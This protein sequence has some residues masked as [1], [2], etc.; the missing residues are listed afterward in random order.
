MNTNTQKTLGFFLITGLMAMLPGATQAQCGSIYTTNT[1]LTASVVCSGNGPVLAASNITLD[2][3]GHTI[4][5]IGSGIGI[6][7]D[8]VN[9]SAVIN[10]S[11]DNFGVG[12]RIDGGSHNRLS[13]NTATNNQSTSG[14]FNI[15]NG[16]I[17]NWLEGN[18]SGFNP[19][20]R[21]FSVNDSH[22]NTLIYNEAF[23]NGFRGFDII[24]ADFNTLYGNSASEQLKRWHGRAELRRRDIH[25]EPAPQELHRGE[26]LRGPG[27]VRLGQHGRVPHIRQQRNL[28]NPGHVGWSE[29]LQQQQLHRQPLGDL[30]AVAPAHSVLLAVVFGP[31]GIRVDSGSVPDSDSRRAQAAGCSE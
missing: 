25:R 5:G 12:F 13:N 22:K 15:T 2:C 20:G 3:A 18:F 31:S 6:L 21:G 4:S 23:N 16:S 7:L 14:G 27:N 8:N 17:G 1:T 9:Q 19:V 30:L 26:R 24:N 10:C 11:V 28:G 29:H